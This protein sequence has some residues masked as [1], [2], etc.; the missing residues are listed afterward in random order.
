MTQGK[1]PQCCLRTKNYTRG[2]GL[3]A[4]AQGET[5]QEAGGGGSSLGWLWVRASLGS[6]SKYGRFFCLHLSHAGHG[7]RD[8]LSRYCR[9]DCASPAGPALH[10]H[11]PSPACGSARHPSNLLG[12]SFLQP[13][14][15]YPPPRLSST[16][17]RS[18]G[19]GQEETFPLP[20]HHPLAL[21]KDLS[22]STEPGN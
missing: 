9:R 5:G 7:P 22:Y 4:R 1:G 6:L 3:R 20:A 17:R 13:G 15:Q 2:T 16:P 21:P 18:L 14:V 12:L 10:P 19:P 8:L 11:P